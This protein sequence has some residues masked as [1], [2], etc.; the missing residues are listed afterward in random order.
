MTAT[1]VD[2]GPQNGWFKVKVEGEVAAVAHT[3]GSILNPEGVLLHVYR[4][5]LITDV[6]ADAAVTLDIGIGVTGAD[7]SDICA[8]YDINGAA[9]HDVIN[10]VGTDLASEGAATTPKGVDWGATEYLNFYVPDAA[11]SANFVGY[12]YLKYIRTGEDVS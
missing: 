4:G 6:D 9:H 1:V 8:A 12:A 11:S 10:L 7:S 5:F 3:L 2:T